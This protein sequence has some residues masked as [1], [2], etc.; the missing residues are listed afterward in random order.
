M[1]KRTLLG[2]SAFLLLAGTVQ[3]AE[4]DSYT[5]SIASIY[6]TGAG[7]SVDTAG[8]TVG[9]S[10]NGDILTIK[11]T[12]GGKTDAYDLKIQTHNN[13]AVLAKNE[14]MIFSYRFGGGAFEWSTGIGKSGFN[15]D[16]GHTG[17]QMRFAGICAAD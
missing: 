3:A 8:E 15:R 13:F 11:N 17:K 10:I 4:Q 6:L 9:F 1:K 14:G 7:R 16:L 2:L 12:S 5:C